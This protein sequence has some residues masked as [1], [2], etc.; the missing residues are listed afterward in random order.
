MMAERKKTTF[1]L[2][3]DLLRAAKV[4]AARE[5]RPE[6]QIVEDALR[7]HLGMDVLE[8]VWARSS[9]SDDEATRL[10]VKEVRSHR[11][12]RARKS[13]PG[14]PARKRT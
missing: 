10:A 7:R 6:Y 14:K 2:D 11:R 4:A 1:Y 5:D 8:R 3:A 13:A 12:E 9:L